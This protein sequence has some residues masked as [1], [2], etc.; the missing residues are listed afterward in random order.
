MALPIRTQLFDSLLGTQ[1]SIHSVILPDV[2]SSGG[3]QNLYIDQFARAKRVNGYTKRNSS[4]L[5]TDTGGSTGIF[6]SLFAY[7]SQ[8][9]SH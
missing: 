1:E 7:R 6:R 2:F 3:S 5:T 9:V 4:P 8:A